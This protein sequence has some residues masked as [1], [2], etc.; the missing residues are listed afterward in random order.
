M[1]LILD[2][3][4]PEALAL[5][6]NA[7]Y[8]WL[9]GRLKLDHQTANE[10]ALAIAEAARRELGGGNH[11][12]PKGTDWELSRRDR[13]I[14]AKFHGNNYDLLA[15]EYDLTEMRIRQIIDRCRRADIRARQAPLFPLDPPTE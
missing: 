9:T 3:D 13:E 2:D 4:Y 1:S 12:I 6:A 14:Y 8:M 11:Y 7:A 5:I 15:R 10:G